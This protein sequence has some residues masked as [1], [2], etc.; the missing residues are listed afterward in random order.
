MVALQPEA[1]RFEQL[2]ALI[3]RLGSH[4]P[5]WVKALAQKEREERFTRD[6]QLT[7]VM[8]AHVLIFIGVWAIVGLIFDHGLPRVP[9]LWF[10]ICEGFIVVMCFVVD[11]ASPAP[12]VSAGKKV[13]FSLRRL[14]PWID[15]HGTDFKERCM[16]VA[17][18]VAYVV[19]FVAFVPLLK[20]TGGPI[21]SPFA[22]MALVIGIFTPFIANKPWTMGFAVTT[23]VIYYAVFVWQ[24]GFES[25]GAQR[26]TAASFVAVNVLILL[27]AFVLTLLYQNRREGRS[28]GPDG[29]RITFT[30]MIDASR[31]LVWKAWTDPSMLIN[32]FQTGDTTLS[33]VE[34][35]VRPGGAW[36]AT[37]SSNGDV[38]Q[39][40]GLYTE[41]KEPEKLVFTVT[42]QDGNEHRVASVALVDLEGRTQ[43]VFQ[44]S[45]KRNRGYEQGWASVFERMASDLEQGKAT[46]DS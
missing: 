36:Q 22:Q 14:E 6:E 44:E 32:W 17:L 35:D 45:D 12:F 46:P 38:T 2:Q 42:D 23:T 10:N 39:W 8:T 21:D 27:L 19:Q 33:D 13:G 30:R 24:F 16:A 5:A 29:S 25:K 37:M 18:L 11:F 3:D 28:I 9:P 1:S 15:E 7:M 43:M 20:A 4:V 34:M 31:D 41:V 26:P 40:K